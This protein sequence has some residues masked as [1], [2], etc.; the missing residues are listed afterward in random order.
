MHT[1]RGQNP[2]KEW[3]IFSVVADWSSPVHDS[4]DVVNLSSKQYIVD[5]IIDNKDS[6]FEDIKG[7]EKQIGQTPP[8]VVFHNNK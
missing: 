8:P 4:I 3:K 5:H 7:K 2:S 1:A 6:N